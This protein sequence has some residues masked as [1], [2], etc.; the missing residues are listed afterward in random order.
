MVS[1]GGAEAA[2]LAESAGLFLDPWQRRLLDAGLGEQADG[3]CAAQRVGIICPRQNGKNATIEAAELYWLFL[4]PTVELITHTAHQFD[5]AVEHF[6]RLLELV[7]GTPDLARQVKNVSMSHGRE[8]VELFNGKRLLLKARGAKGGGSGFSGD[9][10][11]FDEA[12]YL[13]EL[14]SLVPTLSARPDPQIWWSSS[15]PR[16]GPGSDKLRSW[17]A[18]GRESES[19]V[20]AE[21]S[22][23]E[24]TDLGDRTA[25]ADANPSYRIRLSERFVWETERG[26]MSDEEFA[27][28]RFGIF[29]DPSTSLDWST[30]DEGT[31][32]ARAASVEGQAWMRDPVSFGIY[33]AA[34]QSYSAIAAAGDCRD[35]GRC[36]ELVDFAPRTE[37]LV[38]RLA[39]LC[40]RHETSWVVLNPKTAAGVFQAQLVERGVPVKECAGGDEQRAH[41]GFF[42]DLLAGGVSHPGDEILTTAARKAEPRKIGDSWVWNTRGSVA[43]LPLAAASLALWGAKLPPRVPVDV[44]ASVW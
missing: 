18:Q 44:A 21:W 35:G 7:N 20:Y 28:E 41:G 16:P 9:R 31:W 38:D 11:V 33:V 24:G 22:A 1:S 8:G 43:V 19:E 29:P 2:A 4:D 3:K 34:D 14:G 17:I 10:I 15:A 26:S 42:A 12:W 36:V 13:M 30:I 27:R 39:R 25:C 40:E 23:P 6:L 37:W 32:T 5:T